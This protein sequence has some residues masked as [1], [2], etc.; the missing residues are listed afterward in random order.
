MPFGIERSF[1]PHL[2]ITTLQ[3]KEAELKKESSVIA[4]ELKKVT[5]TQ[6]ALQNKVDLNNKKLA[7]YNFYSQSLTGI[8][9]RHG[10]NA[11]IRLKSNHFKYGNGNNFLKRV[12]FSKRYQTERQKAS[13]LIGCQTG[14]ATVSQAKIWQASEA[15][16]IAQTSNMLKKEELKLGS[17]MNSLQT[18]KDYIK[19]ELDTVNQALVRIESE[20]KFSQKNRS[21]FSVI[22]QSNIGC[23]AVNIEARYQFSNSLESSSLTGSKVIAEYEKVHGDTI[24]SK[25]NKEIKDEIK[26]LCKDL[27]GLVKKG[28]EAMYTPSEKNITTWRGQNM[29]LQGMNN[30]LENFSK[31]EFLYRPGQFLS[32]SLSREVAKEFAKDSQGNVKVIFK[33][34]GNSSNPL[35]PGHGLRFDNDE[36]ERLYSP[37]ANFKVTSIKK[38]ANTDF[39][40]IEMQEVERNDK[41]PVLPF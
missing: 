8:S 9:S 4:R 22:Y 33:I 2:T 12:M 5:N 29:T 19:R 20:K 18:E 11:T 23:A 3:K 40:S 31:G 28:A 39:Y 17:Q 1:N 15:E 38:I 34:T 36:K 37:L 6:T 32:T 7:A 41:A 26:Y 35:T 25:G 24:F 30:L 13:E 21:D 27:P 10:E 14:K 16:K